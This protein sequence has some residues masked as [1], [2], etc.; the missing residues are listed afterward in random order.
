RCEPAEARQQHQPQRDQGADA[1]I[2]EQGHGER[3]DQQ[4]R[5]SQPNAG[6]AE[7]SPLQRPPA[8]A[9]SSSSSSSGALSNERHS[10]TGMRVPKT[11]LSLSALFQNEAKLSSTPTAT[12]PTAVRG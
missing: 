7:D 8:H 5:R 3:G 11:M 6:G 9:I 1:D 10:N 4:W 12:A 2:V